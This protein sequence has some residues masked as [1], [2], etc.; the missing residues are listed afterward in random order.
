MDFA[1]GEIGKTQLKNLDKILTNADPKIPKILFLHHIPT[2]EANYSEV[3]SLIDWDQ[4]VQTIS[5][6]VDVFAFGHQSFERKNGNWVRESR[7]MQIRMIGNR[8]ILDADSSVDEQSSYLIAVNKDKINVE[9][10]VLGQ[11]LVKKDP[12]APYQPNPQV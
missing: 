6:R 11:R 9:V 8:Y 10:K 12:L 3:M 4:L 5:N 1:Q 2:G 7:K